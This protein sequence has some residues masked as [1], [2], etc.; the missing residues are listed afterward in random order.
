M[1]NRSKIEGPK[2]T[3]SS[4]AT[5]K[6]ASSVARRLKWRRAASLLTGKSLRADAQHQSAEQGHSDAAEDRADKGA[7]Q[8][9]GAAK[10][11]TGESESAERRARN[12]H[13]HEGA[14]QPAD[15]HIGIDAGERRQEHSGQASKT[16][17]D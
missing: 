3:A 11:E 12:H 2:I 13:Q 1:V 17:A 6:I 5:P 8:D 10:D 14:D 15:T 7:D 4:A 16:G 9:L